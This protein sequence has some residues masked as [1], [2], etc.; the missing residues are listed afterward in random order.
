MAALLEV[1]DLRTE[2]HTEGGVVE[3][4]TT[5]DRQHAV[6]TVRDRGPGIPEHALR[7]IFERFYRVPGV[8]GPGSGLGLAVANEFIGWHGGC[9]DVE[10]IEGHGSTFTIRLPMEA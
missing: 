3:V 10:S 1:K 2:F 9:I 6:V 8:Q 5:R 4:S 7:K